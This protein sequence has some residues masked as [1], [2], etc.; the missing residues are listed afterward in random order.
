MTKK[1]GFEREYFLFQGDCELNLAEPRK[2]GL[3]YDESGYLVEARAP[4]ADKALDAAHLLLAEESRLQFEADEK[5]IHLNLKDYMQVPKAIK[6]KYLR[7]YGKNP[8]EAKNLYG[9]TLMESPTLMRAGLHVH[10]SSMKKITEKDGSTYEVLDTQLDIPTIIR[11]LDAKYN[12]AIKLARRIPGEYEL[13]SHGFEYR[14]LPASTDVVTL[15]KRISEL[16][17]FEIQL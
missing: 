7:R 1:I 8:S 14:S 13:K 4:P 3:P 10:F 5:G 11:I 6:A 9:K 2:F 16:E 12:N 17:A 15:A